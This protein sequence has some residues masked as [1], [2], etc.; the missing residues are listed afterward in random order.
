MQSDDLQRFLKKI[1]RTDSHTARVWI[2]ISMRPYD[3]LS[4]SSRISEVALCF[5][6]GWLAEMLL[7][8]AVPG[9]QEDFEDDCLF[10]APKHEVAVLRVLLGHKKGLRLQVTIETVTHIANNHPKNMMALLLDQRGNEVKITQEV[11]VAAAGNSYNGKKVMALLL[12]QRGDEVQITQEMVVS[13]AQHFDEEV[14]T[15]LLDRCEEDVQ[16]TQE[17]LITAA[18]NYYN[19]K[20]VTKLLLDRLVDDVQITPDVVIVVVGIRNAMKW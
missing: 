3:R 17:V 18:G 14:M 13:I 7:D 15:L 12:S 4:H 20:Q 5:D 11:V 2:E 10:S 16:I 1:V 6:I 8:E 19:S 9:I